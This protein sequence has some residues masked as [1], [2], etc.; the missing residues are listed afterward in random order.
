MDGLAIV[1]R[2]RQREDGPASGEAGFDHRRRLQRLER[3]ARQYLRRHVAD[4]DLD[5]AD[6]VQQYET[7]GVP[8]FAAA[9]TEHIDEKH[10]LA[11]DR[12]ASSP[13]IDNRPSAAAV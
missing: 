5:L 11:H 4:G 12:S 10:W 3:R 8:R 13:A 9:A 1:T 2:S 7:A 6:A